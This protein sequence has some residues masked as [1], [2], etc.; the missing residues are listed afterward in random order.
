MNHRS[1]PDANAAAHSHARRAAGVRPPHAGLARARLPCRCRPRRLRADKAPPHE[2]LLSRSAAD[3]VGNS[4]AR[5]S[6]IYVDVAVASSA[7][8]TAAAPPGKPGPPGHALRENDP[9][10]I[11]A[12]GSR[13][14]HAGS[15]RPIEG[16]SALAPGK[17]PALP[18]GRSRRRLR[19]GGRREIL[20]ADS[21][22]WERTEEVSR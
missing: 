3:W 8:A 1:E 13:S 14:S 19:G 15:R 22:R 2:G 12:F 11:P 10:W 20:G 9:A 5:L 21:P 4:P 17:R 18:L 6:R 16:D 7:A